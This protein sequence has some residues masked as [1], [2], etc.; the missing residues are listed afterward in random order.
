[1]E[2]KTQA[3]SQCCVV[4]AASLQPIP[5]RIT[6]ANSDVSGGAASAKR[7]YQ[8]LNL[9]FWL[10][11]AGIFLGPVVAV[12]VAMIL[13]KA[14]GS[15]VSSPVA[16]S[17]PL[18]SVGALAVVLLVRSSRKSARRSVELSKLAAATGLE[19]LDRPDV[20]I[21]EFFRKISFM[22]DPLD[23]KATN[24]LLGQPGGR[25]MV[26]ADYRYSYFYGAFSVVGEETIVS[27][28]ESAPDDLELAI[29]PNSL[30]DRLL[31]NLT[32][33]RT[34]IKTP[35]FPQFE[36]R[37]YVF[38]GDQQYLA[39]LLRPELVNLF[40]QDPKLTLVVEQGHVLVFRQMT[41]I[42]TSEY[43]DF[44]RKALALTRV[45]ASANRPN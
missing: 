41:Y 43:Q 14:I 7:R 30:A 1:M 42:P 25:R 20:K 16:L 39:S 31:D 27:F 37:F 35:H 44:I 26:A 4:Q 18:W 23:S 11:I 40:L 5:E 17:A 6:M 28:P 12:I 45:V 36:Q 9:V 13:F 24:V 22:A 33:S 8:R 38:G 32:G 21:V 19:F 3:V 2:Y 15:E 34:A 29:V 10:G